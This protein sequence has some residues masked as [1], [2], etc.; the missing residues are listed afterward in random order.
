[1]EDHNCAVHFSRRGG[2][3]LSRVGT[4]E[5]RHTGEPVDT[6]E[7]MAG[8]A[9]AFIQAKGFSQVDLPG[10]SMGSM[11][12]QELVLKDPQLVRTL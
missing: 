11:V 8:D 2:L 3:R 7:Q 10:F 9:F 5:R 1:M 6:I 4:E 12:A